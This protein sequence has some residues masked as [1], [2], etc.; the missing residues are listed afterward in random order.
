MPAVGVGVVVLRAGHGGQEVLLIRRG[1]APRHGEWS[2]PGGHQEFGE[3]VRETAQREVMEETGV[4]IANLTLVDV[5]DAF[6]RATN[7]TLVGHWT[8]V[9][10]RADWVAGEPKAGDDAM[11]A[12]W[13]PLSELHGYPLWTE[14]L[15]IIRNAVT[16]GSGEEFEA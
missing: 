16:M 6:R 10:F 5:V 14:T 4:T 2:I 11:E 13:V 9:D 15:R 12:R 1:K 3:T 8:L 7:G